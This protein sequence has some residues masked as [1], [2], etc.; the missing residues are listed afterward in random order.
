MGL[1]ALSGYTTIQRTKEIGIRKVLGASAQGIVFLLTRDLV[2]LVLIAIVIA[3]PLT[4]W[5]MEQ[6]L[7]NFANRIDISWTIFLAAGLLTL[8][9]S[10]LTVSIQTIKAARANPAES[11]RTE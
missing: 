2:V 10:F 8:V 11:I 3:S 4:W 9:V 7:Q 1:F 6:W 5:V